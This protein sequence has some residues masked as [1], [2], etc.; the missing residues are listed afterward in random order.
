MRRKH[1]NDEDTYENENNNQLTIESDNN[2]LAKS[3]EARIA[4]MYHK[5]V[6]H[7]FIIN[8][9]T[10]KYGWNHEEEPGIPESH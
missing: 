6:C 8:I 5:L 9:R 4:S 3:K 2:I 1:H 10:T 7:S